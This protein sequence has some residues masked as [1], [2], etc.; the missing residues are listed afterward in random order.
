MKPSG[1]EAVRAYIGAV[2]DVVSLVGKAAQDR[3]IPWLDKDLDKQFDS[4]VKTLESCRQDALDAAMETP[5]DPTEVKRW[6]LYIRN[7]LGSFKDLRANNHVDVFTQK[8]AAIDEYLEHFDDV[9]HKLESKSMDRGLERP[10]GN[11]SKKQPTRRPSGPRPQN[12]D[13]LEFDEKERQNDPN[14][15]DKEI[16]RRFKLKKPKHPVF[17]SGNPRGALRAARYRK[18][19]NR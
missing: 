17:D 7:V 1:S 5:F 13:L 16:L 9:A 14:I 2:K 19:K 8:S 12:A 3:H 11:K 18:D 15:T 6:Q 10:S 4:L